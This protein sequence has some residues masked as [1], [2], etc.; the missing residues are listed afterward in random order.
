MIA[1]KT[2]T[3]NYQPIMFYTTSGYTSDN[4]TEYPAQNDKP[5]IY[6]DKTN[7]IPF[8]LLKTTALADPLTSAVLYNTYTG[9]STSIYSLITTQ[10]L[11]DYS[12][13]KGYISYDGTSTVNA[14]PGIYKMICSDGTTTWTSEIFCIVDTTK[15]DYVKIEYACSYDNF[16]FIFQD[17]S[18]WFFIE[19]AINTEPDEILETFLTNEDNEN[20]K[21]E[22]I[23]NPR[24]SFNLLIKDWL[25]RCLSLM[26]QCDTITMTVS[27]SLVTQSFSI[28]NL[29]ITS[30]KFDVNY[31][32]STIKFYIVDNNS[33]YRS[34]QQTNITLLT[35]TLTTEGE[36]V[37]TDEEGGS[38]L[39]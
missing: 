26:T 27:N 22:D 32:N 1:V 2:S 21:I 11:T 3:F 15:D 34:N 28:E 17:F 24:Y 8:Q 35:R 33:I 37:L 13:T 12:T 30:P 9:K 5:L 25:H 19:T 39:Q 14:T 18:F 23:R 31:Y 29:E 10:L 16:N 6:V 36:D 4:Q 38:L 20:T 7:L